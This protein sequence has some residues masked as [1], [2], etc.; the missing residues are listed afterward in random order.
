[1]ARETDTL[2]PRAA[3]GSSSSAPT[4]PRKYWIL[5]FVGAVV[6]V[7]SI[8]GFQN[9]NNKIF[10]QRE[11]DNGIVN[12]AT[13]AQVVVNDN[14]EEGRLDPVLVGKKKKKTKK[15]TKEKK[16]RKH[17]SSTSTSTTSTS[18]CTSSDDGDALTRTLQ[19]DQEVKFASLFRNDK[20]QTKYEASSVVLLDDFAYA[21]C[22]SSWAISKFHIELNPS[23]DIN[24]NVQIGDPRRIPGEDSGYEALFHED[25]V[26]YV[27]RESIKHQDKS[28]H[29]IIEEIV[30]NDNDNNDEDYSIGQVCTCEFEFEGD[31]KGFEGAVALHDLNGGMVILGLCEGN[32][33]SET[34]KNDK[35]NGRLVAMRK[36]LSDDGTSCQ[37]ST[38]RTIHIPPSANFRDYSAIALNSVNGKVAITSQEESQLW[39][40]ELLGFD[41]AAGLWDIDAMEFNTSEERDG[42]STAQVY[43]FPKN[44]DCQT[45]YC[46]IEGIHWMDNDGGGGGGGAERVMAVSDKMKSKGKQEPQ[47]DEKDQSAHIFIIPS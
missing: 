29:A 21:V 14:E 6:V 38:I 41:E 32:H 28:Y 13:K 40:G 11:Q 35:G 36:E 46:N 5:L 42:T 27:V 16:A 45:V 23:T 7:G 15:D 30:L 47:C 43:D 44:D 37:W 1:M 20:G 19:L 10:Q 18:I 34:R 39:V 8:L 22:D 2:L 3:T 12:A 26:F 33:C 25:G 9:A 17:M 4:Q 24:D 31:S